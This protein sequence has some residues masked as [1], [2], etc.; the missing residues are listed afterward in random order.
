MLIAACAAMA[1][2][3][4]P[5]RPHRMYRELPLFWER[6]FKD[7]LSHRDAYCQQINV[8]VSDEYYGLGEEA[9]RQQV[10]EELGQH[11][12][13][14][15][16]WFH[17]FTGV[18]T[19]YNLKLERQENLIDSYA[20]ASFNRAL[21][22]CETA[23]GACWLLYFEF[24][25]VGLETW[26]E[27][28]LQNLEKHFISSGAQ[29][30]PIISR[31]LLWE[32]DYHAAHADVPNALDKLFWAA[33]FDRNLAT[34][35]LK[36][37]LLQL[38]QS[39]LSISQSFHYYYL[40]LRDSW[41]VQL[42]VL[43][44]LFSFLHTFIAMLIVAFFVTVLLRHLV[45]MLHPAAER[46]PSLVNL[47]IRTAL[48]GLLFVCLLPLGIL[49]FLWIAA[50]LVWHY[51]A[52]SE[53]IIVGLGCAAL[54]AA[55]LK[56]RIDDHLYE[57]TR[58]DA[59]LSLFNKVQDAGYYPEL[60]QLVHF[61]IEQNPD[62]YLA[63]I[64]AASLSLKNK[65]VQSAKSYIS[66]AEILK[67]DDPIVM[68]TH[69]NILYFSN[70]L[71]AAS[72]YFEQCLERFPELEASFF[73]P[74]LYYFGE[75]KFME[76]IDLM[77]QA[78]ELNPVKISSFLKKND[79]YYEGNWPRLRH[80]LQPDY[81]PSIFWNNIALKMAP[82]WN[83]TNL[84][85]KKHFLGL[86]VIPYAAISGVLLLAMIFFSGSGRRLKQFSCKVCGIPICRTCRQQDLCPQ[87][88]EALGD[89]SE[90][91]LLK[92]F[93]R[94]ASA[95]RRKYAAFAPQIITMLFP[96]MGSFF[97]KG[98]LKPLAFLQICVTALVY[99]L[100]ILVH[101]T[102]GDSSGILTA[103]QAWKISAVLLIYSLAYLLIGI[104]NIIRNGRTLI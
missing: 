37:A 81:K 13:E 87:C 28:A 30:A 93:V 20:G 14:N 2:G 88:F 58:A 26:A 42:G 86:G 80:F 77:E 54:I 11:Y 78:A 45:R 66:R 74:C 19:A 72:D 98:V 22:L 25:R 10:S 31:Q 1:A 40:R 68:L 79:K 33:Q 17:F 76:G 59:S 3:Q 85:W 32:S 6:E 97:E 51:L 24:S 55:P 56:T 91:P 44:K 35:P 100:H 4:V 18:I 34:A 102:K 89:L 83:T 67:P 27:Q 73:N 49:P 92:H 103:P 46:Y 84:H 90:G 7:A 53:R 95:F 47:K 43:K 39:L 65:D 29:A 48:A 9:I 61:H 63:Y 38:P 69:G 75:M 99:S 5:S 104:R 71:K 60:E 94:K 12:H 16:V 96:G 62:D 8:S 21:E 57:L 101:A 70:E 23:P 36:E 50:A 52:K 82:K 15:N 41:Q 64:C